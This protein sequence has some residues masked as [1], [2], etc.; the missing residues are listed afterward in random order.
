MPRADGAAGA[1]AGEAGG[2]SAA[3]AVSDAD[4]AS[5]GCSEEAGAGAAGGAAWSGH[6]SLLSRAARGGLAGR[7]RN[8]RLTAA[9]PLPLHQGGRDTWWFR[10]T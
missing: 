5:Q 6:V 10:C 4:V 3:P 1:G 2:L 7:D 8:L 9:G